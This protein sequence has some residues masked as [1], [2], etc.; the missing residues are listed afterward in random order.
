MHLLPRPAR[1]CLIHCSAS[2]ACAR[3]RGPTRGHCSLRAIVP[4]R[5]GHCRLRGGRG[6]GSAERR[7]PSRNAS[8]PPGA[9]LSVSPGNGH[10]ELGQSCRRPRGSGAARYFS[11]GPVGTSPLNHLRSALRPQPR[12]GPEGAPPCRPL[13]SR[14]APG[15]FADA[16]ARPSCTWAAPARGATPRGTERTF[17]GAAAAWR[18]QDTPPSVRRRFPS[19]GASFFARP[20]VFYSRLL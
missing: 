13:G 5:P 15:L 1:P 12:P 10:S 2:A 3:T 8:G 18:S 19:P 9:S 7:D 16:R 4:A 17:S 20:Q 11:C 6:T 14:F